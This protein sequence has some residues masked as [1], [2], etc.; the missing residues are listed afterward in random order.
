MSKATPKVLIADDDEDSRRLLCEVLE[1]NGYEVGA[2]SD[3]RAARETLNRD[4][5][6]G[7]VIADLRMPNESGP[8]DGIGQRAWSSR[9]AREAI[10]AI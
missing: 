4:G 6:Y 10:S 7:I 8:G 9:V 2:V 1:A 5:G 3:G